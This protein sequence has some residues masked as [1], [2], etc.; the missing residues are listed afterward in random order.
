[1]MSTR[2]KVQSKIQWLEVNLLWIF[3]GAGRFGEGVRANN[4]DTYD[5]EVQLE[6]MI[7]LARFCYI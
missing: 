3:L 4:G 7:S 1:M 5:N 2:S 6:Q